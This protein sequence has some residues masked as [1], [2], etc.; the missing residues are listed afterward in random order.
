MDEVDAQVEDAILCNAMQD[1]TTRGILM[2]RGRA[3]SMREAT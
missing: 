1:Y 2:D 3:L